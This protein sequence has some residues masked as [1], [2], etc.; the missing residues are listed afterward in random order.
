MPPVQE[1][2][3]ATGERQFSGT[4]RNRQTTRVVKIYSNF[5]AIPP[6]L[7]PVNATGT[8]IK[9]VWINTEVLTPYWSQFG[10]VSEY[11][12]LLTLDRRHV[13]LTTKHGDRPVGA[14]YRSESSSGALVLLPDIDFHPK[15]FYKK[16]RE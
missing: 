1:F 5:N 6:S 12:V 15:D 3:I 8:G 9:L 7:A 10:N 14:I 4:G 11:K 16:N 13:C 2:F